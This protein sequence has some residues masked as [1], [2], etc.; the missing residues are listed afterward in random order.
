MNDILS[1]SLVAMVD[2][3]WPQIMDVS[4][5]V[6]LV[7][8]TL[9]AAQNLLYLVQL[10][11]AYGVLRNRY[12]VPTTLQAWRQ[13]NVTTLPISLLVPA[14]NEEASIV[15]NIRSMLALH[16]PNFEIIVI[17]DGSSDGTLQAVVDA[18]EL[19]PVVRPFEEEVLHNPIRGVYGSPNHQNLIVVDKENGGKA[20]ALN[21]GINLS[22][23]PL[24][25]AVDADSLLESDALLRAVQPFADDPDRVVAVGGT[26]RIA[27]GC[28]VRAGRVVSVGM[29]SNVVALFQIV[30]YLRAYL[31]ARLAWSK[32]D[33][34]ML[35]SG[36]FGIFKRNVAI[37]VGGYSHGT[38]GEDMEI[39]VKIHR[40]MR[41]QKREYEIRFVP[42]PVCWTEVPESMTVLG[43]QRRR[44]QRGALETFFKHRKMLFNRRYGVAGL[45]G[46]PHVLVVDVLGPPV[47]VVGYLLMPLFWW[48]G[49]FSLDFLL[50]YLALT[51]IFGVTISIGSLIL[52]EMELKR[53][54][55]PSHLAVL[56]GV[57]VLE[58]FGY[59]QINNFWR[60]VGFWQFLRGRQEWGKME[61]TGFRKS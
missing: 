48:M 32:L 40:H 33:A 34:L 36:A 15:E 44:W 10:F 53:F 11:I 30:E 38:V 51:F 22:R 28:G 31:M 56:T 45:L 47:E 42:D 23:F 17:N 35:I 21:A 9:M 24:F 13:L 26:I 55:S 61:R 12:I 3:A 58:N 59:R 43:R 8:M 16:Y 29:P 6:S 50:A 52:E 2:A 19:S 4:F 20:D 25:C 18:F 37:E 41:E 7:I 1:P 5:G 46:F 49:V 60:I 54:P 27:N 57:A 39:I 14:Y